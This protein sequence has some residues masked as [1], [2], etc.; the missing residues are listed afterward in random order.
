MF[1]L[2][3]AFLITL[4][5]DC[6][7]DILDCCVKKNHKDDQI[8]LSWQSLGPSLQERIIDNITIE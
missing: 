4:H 2:F 5:D 8:N 1:S 6:Y 3:D 7:E